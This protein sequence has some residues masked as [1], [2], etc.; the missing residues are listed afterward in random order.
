MLRKEMCSSSALSGPRQGGGSAFPR[1]LTVREVCEIFR[2]TDRTIRRWVQD[3]RLTPVRIGR[4]VFFREGEVLSLLGLGDPN[5]H[6][7][8]D[9][10]DAA[11]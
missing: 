6:A 8:A 11:E 7:E 2:R 10:D 5:E 9:H 1:L 3:G 4:S